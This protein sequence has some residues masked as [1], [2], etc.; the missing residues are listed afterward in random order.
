M[1]GIIVFSGTRLIRVL[2]FSTCGFQC[3]PG[4][5]SLHLVEEKRMRKRANNAFNRPGNAVAH[6]TS[7][8]FPELQFNH[9][10]TTN[11]ERGWEM[12]LSVCTGRRGEHGL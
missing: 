1:V 4:F 2:R 7:F 6:K 3:H 12:W 8:T 11:C 10:A 9:R 5:I